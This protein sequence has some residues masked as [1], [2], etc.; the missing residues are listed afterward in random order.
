MIRVDRSICHR[1][2]YWE[3]DHG[4]EFCYNNSFLQSRP[5]SSV[6]RCNRDYPRTPIFERTKYVVPKIFVQFLLS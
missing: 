1:C 3:F 4:K 6:L 5:L 2:V